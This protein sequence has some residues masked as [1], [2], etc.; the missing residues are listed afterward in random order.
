MAPEYLLM[1]AR[2]RH[3]YQPDLAAQQPVSVRPDPRPA[4]KAFR[5]QRRRHQAFPGESFPVYRVLLISETSSGR[6]AALRSIAIL[7]GS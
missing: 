3:T 7:S 1:S 2:L 6:I 5:S 4:R